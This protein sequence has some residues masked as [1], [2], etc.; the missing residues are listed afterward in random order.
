MNYLIYFDESNKID[1]FNKD[2]S[3]YGAYGAT[4]KSL[5]AIVKKTKS[6]YKKFNSKSELHFAEYNKDRNIKKYFQVLNHVINEELRINILIVNNLDALAAAEKIGLTTK[7][8]RNLFYIKI[9]ERLFYGV[10]RG[11][12]HI[13]DPK[14]EKYINVK[15][16]IDKNDEYDEIK[17]HEKLIEQMNAHSAYRNK[18]YRVNKV[19]SQDS[20]KSIPLQIID[21]FMGIVVFLLEKSYLEDSDNTKIKS[22]LI[23]RFLVEKD[24]IFKFQEN[25]KLFE[26]TGREELTPVNISEHVAPFI[27]YKSKYDT[28]EITRLQ[29]VIQGSPSLTT[30]ELR[31]KMG[32]PN[33]MLNQLL[34]YKDQ[35]T[36]DGRNYFL[37]RE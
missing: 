9:P 31:E 19:F 3:Y 37:N 27:I 17:L 14:N 16:K 26:W 12:S 15:I 5:A 8:L 1:Q 11:L 25:I 6:I 24:N 18:N 10:T 21:T 30:R 20:K 22:D 2:F 28:E 7:E 33:T 29:K 23:Y 32:Y 35:I 13:E 36:G 4:D 34:G